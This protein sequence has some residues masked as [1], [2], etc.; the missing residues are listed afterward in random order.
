MTLLSYCGSADYGSR[1]GRSH[2][3]HLLAQQRAASALDQVELRVDLVGRNVLEGRWT[4]QIVEEFDAT[5]WQ[6]ARDLEGRA[7]GLTG[8][9]RHVL[10]S[11]MKERRRSAGRRHHEQRPDP[12]A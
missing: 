8:G 7:R 11:E 9:T 6:V 12:G 1:I 3:D 10:E 5:Y 4:F 2:L